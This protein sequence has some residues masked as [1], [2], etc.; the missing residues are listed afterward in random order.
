LFTPLAAID[1]VLHDVIHFSRR[2]GGQAATGPT[3]WSTLLQIG[4]W[5]SWT[6][7]EGST[8][9]TPTI[10][11]VLRSRGNRGVHVGMDSPI[12]CDPYRSELEKRG[13][14]A[15]CWR[16]TGAYPHVGVDE[17]VEADLE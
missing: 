11:V 3:S 7:L 14:T 2:H 6:G 16:T 5:A 15:V 9:D 4:C 13:G 10:G 17:V 8:G 12:S 1:H